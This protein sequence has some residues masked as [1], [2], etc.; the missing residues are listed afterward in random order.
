RIMG[1]WMFWR[2]R[3]SVFRGFDRGRRGPRGGWGSDSSHPEDSIG[4]RRVISIQAGQQDA[5]S[6][7]CLLPAALQDD[8]DALGPKGDLFQLPVS[9]AIGEHTDFASVPD[10]I[11]VG[12]DEDTPLEKARLA[13]F[14]AA[15]GVFVVEEFPGHRAGGAVA[16]GVDAIETAV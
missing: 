7:G 6:G 8:A 12:V 10:S 16:L 9:R 2:K 4:K 11:V 1:R 3:T 5:F 14:F 15:I 13:G